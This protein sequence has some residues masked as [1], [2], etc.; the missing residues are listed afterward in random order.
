M[1]SLGINLVHAL[2]T[3]D[4]SG[5][6]TTMVSDVGTVLLS[7]LTTVLGVIAALIGLFFVLR[8]ITKKIGG[9]K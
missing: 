7:G 9:T 2:D 4:A 8:L 5:L 6:V 1:I 3:T